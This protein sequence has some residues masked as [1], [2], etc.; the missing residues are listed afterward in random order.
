MGITPA[1]TTEQM[2]KISV[3]RID[4]Q[5]ATIDLRAD[6][7]KK[8]LDLRTLMMAEKPN[9]QKIHA[10]IEEMGALKT[11]LQKQRVFHQLKVRE[12]LTLEQRA[13]RKARGLGLDGRR[14]KRHPR[15]GHGPDRHL[16][17]HWE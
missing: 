14:G 1:L 7:Q 6:L 3:L 17:P 8:Q 13:S 9:E 12:I 10:V 15:R 4:H 16:G 5:K 11:Q 2:E